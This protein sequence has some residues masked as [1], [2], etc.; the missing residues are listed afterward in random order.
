MAVFKYCSQR[1]HQT[2]GSLQYTKGKND[3]LFNFNRLNINFMNF[4][5]RGF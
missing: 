3:D 4:T 1:Q 5:P 2:F